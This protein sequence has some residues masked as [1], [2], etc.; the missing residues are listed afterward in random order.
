[1]KRMSESI[2]ESVTGC[3]VATQNISINLKNRQKAID[4]FG[5]GP[6][7]PDENEANNTALCKDS[8]PKLPR[9]D[10]YRGQ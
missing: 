2:F 6:A 8:K 1:M 4:K 5:Y 10:C 3:P 9:T 7:N